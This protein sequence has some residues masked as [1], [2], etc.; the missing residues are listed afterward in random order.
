MNL[1][2]NEAESRLKTAI[3][4]LERSRD[5]IGIHFALSKMR[6]NTENNEH[7]SIVVNVLR[8]QLKSAI[9]DIYSFRDG[10][11]IIIYRGK[12][13]KLIQDC[14]FQV[15]YLFAD[16]P[17]Q[18]SLGEDFYEEYCGVYHPHAWKSFM[19]MCEK[20]ISQ[21]LN[22]NK[23]TFKGSMLSMFSSI[24]EDT[25]INIDWSVLVRTSP[26]H[27]YDPNG[28]KTKVFDEI[29]VDVDS[30]SYIIG[31]N[32]DLKNNK[33]LYSYLKELLDI[34][35]LVRLVQSIAAGKDDSAFLLN[36]NISTLQLPEF[37][38]LAESL[39]ENVKKRIIIAI[40]VSEVFWDLSAYLG[41][42]EQI[43]ANGFK[44]C[45]DS[46]EYLSFMQIDRNSLGFDLVRI[47]H[48][49]SF[50]YAQLVELEQQLASKISISGSSRVMLQTNSEESI[51]IGQKLGLMLF[52]KYDA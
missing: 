26:I 32:F 3:P 16:D 50:D 42:R 20:K 38:E 12:N 2:I 10:D 17:K 45:L 13:E 39:P 36:L 52:Q 29:F 49:D 22:D 18:L 44:L 7:I 19:E 6:R 27:R 25:L 31:E 15:Q 14:I 37:W 8:D 46:L 21:F 48:D 40:S 11:I 30:I 43:I 33:Y 9:G 23:P 34:K 47:K 5:A 1:Y 41:I 4:S 35:L 51:E 24:I 28:G